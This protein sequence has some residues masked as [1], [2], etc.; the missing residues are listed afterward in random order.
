[1]TL[2]SDGLRRGQYGDQKLMLRAVLMEV[3]R[4]ES[5]AHKQSDVRG[6]SAPMPRRFSMR[7]IRLGGPGDYHIDGAE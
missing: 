6:L 1:M 3:L 7:H 5:E 4:R 2:L